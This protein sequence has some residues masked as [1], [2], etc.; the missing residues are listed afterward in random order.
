MNIKPLALGGGYREVSHQDGHVATRG[1]CS[2]RQSWQQ[3]A[4][5]HDQADGC[6]GGIKKMNGW[7][8]LLRQ[9][10]GCLH[11]MVLWE[12]LWA[13]LVEILVFPRPTGSTLTT[14][15]FSFTNKGRFTLWTGGGWREFWARS[16][17]IL[18]FASPT[19]YM[20]T[21]FGFFLLNWG[22]FYSSFSKWLV[23]FCSLELQPVI[24]QTQT[25][26]L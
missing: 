17:K 23:F 24:F 14:S 21:S 16:V 19:G 6:T 13:R 7:G 15:G 10:A 1:W 9:A 20:L 8:A 26:C 3:G 4:T 5:W 25:V 11:A 2:G 22:V 12:I 18:M